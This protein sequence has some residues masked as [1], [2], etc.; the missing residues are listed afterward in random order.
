MSL[1]DGPKGLSERQSF[2]P[3]GARGGGK[4]Q[5]FLPPRIYTKKY[6]RKE[7]NTHIIN[8]FLKLLFFP[9]TLGQSGK[10]NL[11]PKFISNFPFAPPPIR[12]RILVAPTFARIQNSR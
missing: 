6:N 11:Q 1:T 5:S 9:N 8:T 3:I 4:T 2:T 10:I 12:E 7:S